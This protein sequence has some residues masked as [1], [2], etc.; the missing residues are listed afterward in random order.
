MASKISIG[1]D[2]GPY[3]EL[4]E[5]SGDYVITVPNN[6]IDLDASDIQNILFIEN[7]G[8]SEPSTPD[9]GEFVRWYDSTDE[10][11]K[12]KFDDGSSLTIAQK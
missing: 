4:N 3:V 9:A 2:G 12:A 8:T 1:P 7:D 11:W 10:E 6:L 5:D